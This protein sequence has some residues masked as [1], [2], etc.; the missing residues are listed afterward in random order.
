MSSEKQFERVSLVT[1][2]AGGIGIAVSRALAQGGKHVIVVD[3]DAGRAAAAAE[4]LR[5]EGLSASHAA[6]DVSSA[7]AV[8]GMRQS[9]MEMGRTVDVLANLAGVVRNAILTKVTDEDFRL[10]MECH[11]NGTLNTMRAFAPDMKQ[12]RYGRIVNTSSIAVLGSVAG[13]AYSAAKAAIEGLSRTAAIELAPHGITVNCVAPG[14]IDTGMFLT[15]PKD[16]QE[17]LLSRT[18]MKRVGTPDEVAACVRFFAS[19]EAS[20]VTGQTLFVCGGIT[21]GVLS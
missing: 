1:G 8:S 19:P 18:P 9:L 7:A 14:I 3:L 15:T 13:S 20:F 6:C 12:Q 16:F 21:V 11:V 5:G 2:G 17:R 10:T 4:Q